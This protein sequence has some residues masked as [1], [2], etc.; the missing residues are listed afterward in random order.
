MERQGAET[1]LTTEEARSG[2]TRNIMR[3]VLLIGVTLAVLALSAIWIT[4]ALTS[5]QPDKNGPISGQ[6]TPAA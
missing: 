4:G 2:E 5:A 6:A 1:H 3:W